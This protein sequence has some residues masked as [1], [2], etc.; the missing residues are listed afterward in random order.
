MKVCPDCDRIYN[1]EELNFC[2]MDGAPLID[3]ASQ[4]TVTI[5]VT[6]AET[7]VLTPR[8]TRTDQPESKRKTRILLPLSL[9][10]IAL[11]VGAT[12]GGGALYYVMTRKSEAPKNSGL[13]N[14]PA[15]TPR[16]TPSKTVNAQSPTPENMNKQV[17]E[18]EIDAPID[19]T[20]V[21]WMTTGVPFEESESDYTT[22]L[23]PRNGKEFPVFGVDEYSTD[24]SICTAAVHA[25]LIDFDSGGKVKVEFTSGRKAYGG[26]ERNGVTS[27]P[28]GEAETSFVFRQPSTKSAL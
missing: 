24:S 1:D 6:G 21:L 19:T 17:D 9:A 16:V 3:G 12:V 4:P 18:S 25:G 15:K 11:I 5:P 20:A 22:F 13:E 2:L 27:V 7:L 10:V 28:A 8:S 14:P 26:S 23:C